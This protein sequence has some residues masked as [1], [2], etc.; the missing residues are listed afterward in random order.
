MLGVIEL[1]QFHL[2]HSRALLIRLSTGKCR[3]HGFIIALFQAGESAFPGL[4]VSRDN[5]F[6]PW[7]FS[8]STTISVRNSCRSFGVLICP[9]LCGL[10]RRRAAIVVLRSWRHHNGMGGTMAV[11]P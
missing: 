11:Q 8:T 2:R 1:L 9:C 10:V 7:P 5:V 4:I 6:P 3:C